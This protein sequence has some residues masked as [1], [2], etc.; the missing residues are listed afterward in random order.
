VR[1]SQDLLKEEMLVK[2]ETNQ[3]RVVAKM[4]SWLEKM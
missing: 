3:E 2:M 1:A 4:D